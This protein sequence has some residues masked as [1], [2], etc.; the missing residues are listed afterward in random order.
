LDHDFNYFSQFLHRMRRCGQNSKNKLTPTLKFLWAVSIFDC[1]FWWRFRQDLFA[2]WAE[3][4]YCNAK[5]GNLG[6]VAWL[7]FWSKFRK[8]TSLD[9]FTRFEL[10]IVQIRSRFFL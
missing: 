2:I 4:S 8:Y 6:L 3:N 5:F 9:D 1:E 10:L 7:F